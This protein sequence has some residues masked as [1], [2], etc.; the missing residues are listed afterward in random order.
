MSEFGIVVRAVVA[1]VRRK[2]NTKRVPAGEPA[3]MQWPAV[4]TMSG[5]TSTPE[6]P[7]AV[8]WPANRWP[9]QR[10]S[11]GPRGVVDSR[12]VPSPLSVIRD[13]STRATVAFAAA[14]LAP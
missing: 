4:A 9:G 3:S 1:F 6:Q 7:A 13:A 2:P 14:A 5:P 10:L 8:G 11:L 12:E